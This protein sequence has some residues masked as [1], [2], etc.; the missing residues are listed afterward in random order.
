MSER[1]SYTIKEAAEA[2]GIS[3]DVIKAAIHTTD[4]ERKLRAKALSVSERTG[5]ASKYVVLRADL[6]AWLEGLATA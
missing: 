1:L 4:P 6:E 3:A 5:R 2:T